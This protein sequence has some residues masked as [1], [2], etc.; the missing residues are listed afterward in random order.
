MSRIKLK[1]KTRLFSNVTIVTH[2]LQSHSFKLY[3]YFIKCCLHHYISQMLIFHITICFSPCSMPFLSIGSFLMPKDHKLFWWA[4]SLKTTRL[5]L[6]L[7]YRQMLKLLIT[8]TLNK[9]FSHFGKKQIYFLY[10]KKEKR[11][12]LY[13]CD[14]WL[15]YWNAKVCI[16][17]YIY[18]LLTLSHYSWNKRNCRPIDCL[19]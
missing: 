2:N 19:R 9:S 13:A 7:T 11:Q 14:F 18:N 6:F 1:D 3:I 12:E 15:Q 4:Y 17:W 10:S 8:N 5:H 16:F